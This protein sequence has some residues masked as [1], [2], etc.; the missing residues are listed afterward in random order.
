MIFEVSIVVEARYCPNC[1]LQ[2]PQDARYCPYCGFNLAT[3]P[4]ALV[5]RPL[6]LTLIAIYMFLGAI[7]E[8]IV[9]ISTIATGMF[10]TGLLGSL[11]KA[12]GVTLLGDSLLTAIAAYGL[13]NMRHWAWVMSLSL[14]MVGLINGV[15]SIFT[16][17]NPILVASSLLGTLIGI[18]AIVYLSGES[19]MSMFRCSQP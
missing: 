3:L 13:W 1:N 19:V 17:T 15:A 4:R 8:V 5:E 14:L 16:L 9:G 11:T 6:G 2:I 18:A 10:T 12:L 7:V